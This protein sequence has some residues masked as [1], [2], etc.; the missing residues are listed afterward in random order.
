MKKIS[1]NSYIPRALVKDRKSPV[2]IILTRFL[3]L[4]K[5]Y[6]I[7][8]FLNVYTV[9]TIGTHIIHILTK[10]L[11]LLLQLDQIIEFV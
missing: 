11:P 10:L 7:N 8:I 1:L 3:T 9:H 2:P 5:L 6:N 4:L